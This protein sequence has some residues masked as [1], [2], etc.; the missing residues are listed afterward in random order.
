[1]NKKNGFN[2]KAIY[3]P[4]GKAGEYSKWACNFFTGCSNDCI[5]CYCKKGFLGRTWENKPK[6][7][8]CFVDMLDAFNVFRKEL[9]ANVEELKKNGLFF[10]FTSDPLL[11]E[12]KEL[13]WDCVCEAV[14]SDV[15]VQL[16]TKRADFIDNTIIDFI[17]KD[18]VAFGFTLTGCDEF[19]PGASSNKERIQA[20]SKL[21]QL[22]YRTFASIEPIIYPIKSLEVIIDSLESC[23]LFKIGLLSGKKDYG[24]KEILEMFESIKDLSSQGARFYLKDSFVEFIDVER[25]LLSGNFITANYNIFNS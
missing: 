4:R 19:E 17:R 25:K 18:M 8:K 6:L 22:G 15:P 12:V 1:M 7:K 23:D 5:Y 3:N 16:L 2:G 14:M 9:R 11:P 10:T 13:T 20:M 24:R 21:K